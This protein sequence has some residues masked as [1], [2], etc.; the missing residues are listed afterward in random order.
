MAMPRP[1]RHEPQKKPRQS[2]G[3]ALIEQ[4]GEGADQAQ[5]FWLMSST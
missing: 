5:P 2:P 3:L 1:W 4:I